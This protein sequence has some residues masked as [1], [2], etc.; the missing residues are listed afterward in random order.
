MMNWVKKHTL[1]LYFIL[2]YVLVWGASAVHLALS[3]EGHAAGIS[4]LTQVP[5]ALLVLLGPAL[6]ALIAAGV[7][8]GWTALRLML[9]PLLAWKVG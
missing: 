5:A 6:A 4:T 7:E 9:R 3:R 8:G 2:A 1:W